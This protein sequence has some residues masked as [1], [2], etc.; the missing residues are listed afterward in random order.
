MET[1]WFGVVAVFWT[2]FLVL[3]GFD[4]GVGALHMVVGRTDTERRVAIN[5][6][7][8]FWDGN[9]VW[10]VVAGASIFAAFPSWYATWF[11]AL[12]LALMLVLIALI[13]R[14][15]SFEFRGKVDS[16]AWKRTW[17]WALTIG[18][19]LL[20][21]LFGIALGDLLVGLP[22]DQDGEYTGSFVD[23]LTPYGIWVGLTLLALTLLHGAIFLT[24]RTT[25]VVH[26]RA[27]KLAGPFAMIAVLVVLV[28]ATWTHIESDRGIIPGPVQIIAVF[29]VIA[30]AW[31]V[32]DGHD[33]WAF[34][35]TSVAMAATVVSLF[36]DL[37]PNVMVSSTDSANNLTV[38]NSASS[39]YALKVMTIVAV[40]FFPLVLAYQTW[41]YYT[42]R[43]RIR[44]PRA[45]S[46]TTTTTPPVTA[47]VPPVEGR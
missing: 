43:G 37:Y 24:L 6:I 33:G 21:V 3:E 36:I 23:L 47:P 10:L 46:T 40:I 38:A 44:G 9:E 13:M 18:S 11:S 14:G 17:S 15:V 22:I 8:P 7:G 32:R 34:T 41:G 4:F 16:P 20:P 39:P 1:V 28:F 31:S 19:L 30:A 27:R 35:A 2:G 5:T 26:D 29:A 25:G 45:D 12:Y 42:F